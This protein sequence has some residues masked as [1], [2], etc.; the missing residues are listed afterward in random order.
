[1]RRRRRQQDREVGVS[2]IEGPIVEQSPQSPT[3]MAGDVLQLQRRLGNRATQQILAAHPKPQPGTRPANRVQRVAVMGYEQ[4]KSRSSRAFK[5]RSDELLGIDAALIKYH[6]TLDKMPRVQANAL[7]SLIHAIQVWEQS[8]AAQSKDKKTVK[9]SRLEAIIRLKSQAKQ[10]FKEVSNIEDVGSLKPNANEGEQMQAA[11]AI[12]DRIRL[13]VQNIVSIEAPRAGRAAREELVRPMEDMRENLRALATASPY[14]HALWDGGNILIAVAEYHLG[15]NY[16][17]QHHASA[18]DALEVYRNRFARR[19]QKARKQSGSLYFQWKDIVQGHLEQVNSDVEMYLSVRKS[20]KDK[21][22]GVSVGG[23]VEKLHGFTDKGLE[24]LGAQGT[25][26]KDNFG[27]EKYWK[28]EGA[29]N[30]PQK[31]AATIVNRINVKLNARQK[32]HMS[33]AADMAGGG[34]DALAIGAQL[35]KLKNDIDALKGKKD[36]ESKAKRRKLIAE[37]VMILTV[38]TPATLFKVMGGALTAARGGGKL[39]DSNFFGSDAAEGTDMSTDV[40]LI[41]DVFGAVKSAIDSIKGIVK[42]FVN[43]VKRVRAAKES[44]SGKKALQTAFNTGDDLVKNAASVGNVYK[45]VYLI[46]E[47]IKQGGQIVKNASDVSAAAKGTVNNVPVIPVLG[48]IASCIDLVRYVARAIKTGHFARKIG[49]MM[50]SLAGGGDMTENALEAF[51]LARES[52]KKRLNRALINIA[53]AAASIAAGATSLS[54]LG[55]GIGM[56]I[57]MSSAVARI[58]QT[59]VRYIKQKKRDKKGGGLTNIER[60]ATHGAKYNTG[61]EKY[62]GSGKFISYALYKAQKRIGGTGS[63]RGFNIDKSS[64]NKAFRY[65]KAALEILRSSEERQ[66]MFFEMLDIEHKVKIVE[67]DKSKTNKYQAKMDL[68]IDAFKRRD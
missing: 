47:Q 31:D 33:G 11:F 59:G 10:K 15:I 44:G 48:L 18:A 29:K 57:S 17:T 25:D 58:A 52:F 43:F 5:K 67:K 2:A 32:D 13:T 64:E 12:Y 4:W 46:A 14:V 30:D 21:T 20:G 62:M 1:V 40:K 28:T 68:I 9:S 56:I 8:K 22:K 6:A 3:G 24:L 19:I 54:G 50:N 23:T 65:R 38:D 16:L 61:G 7:N 66:K 49:G 41:G 26:G 42:M 60:G 37:Y 45:N 63:R 27:L 35:A 34:L 51:Q 36:K 53:H 55:A 39:P